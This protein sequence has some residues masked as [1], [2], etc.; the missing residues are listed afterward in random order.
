[1]SDHLLTSSRRSQTTT[2]VPIKAGR[3][4]ILKAKGPKVDAAD[5][6]DYYRGR[7][8][9]KLP[10]HPVIDLTTTTIANTPQGLG[11]CIILSSL[12][13]RAKALIYSGSRHFREL[14]NFIPGYVNRITAHW[15]VSAELNRDFDLGNGHG[16]QRLERVCGINPVLKPAGCLEV[17]VPPA[18]R[19]G[20][21]LH[22]EAGHHAKYQ[23]NL[24]HPR[25]RQVYPEN[26]AV[27]QQFVYDHPDVR[28][29][30]LGEKF[31]GLHEVDNCTGLSLSDSI[32]L[33]S[34]CEYFLGIISGPC[35]M[36]AAL[37]LKIVCII[38][39]PSPERIYLPTL[40]NIDQVE[41]EWFYPQAA[42][43]HQDGEGPLVPRFSL[44]NLERAFGGDVYPYW[45]DDYLHLVNEKL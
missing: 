16:I 39:F 20:A 27:I 34:G 10:K 41:S 36:A 40:K 11:D 17:A 42:H 38:N 23:K 43:L 28:F 3:I 15:V 21:V 22:F 32:R 45:S 9:R 31:S 44:E 19:S 35:N 1:M 5:I 24:I 30:E 25:P 8:S 18:S 2:Q 14:T 12:P 7:T 13:S 33:M 26:M 29:V 37:G 4:N 6:L